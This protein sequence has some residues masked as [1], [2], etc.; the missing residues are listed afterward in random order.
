MVGALSPHGNLGSLESPV[1]RDADMQRRA[2]LMCCKS[3]SKPN[4]GGPLRCLCPN[5]QSATYIP[6]EYSILLQVVEISSQRVDRNTNLEVLVPPKGGLS[7]KYLG[8][9]KCTK[10]GIC[11]ANPDR[12][13]RHS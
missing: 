5:A 12:R 6:T 1:A 9:H 4:S 8:Y 10:Q 2:T 13:H 11:W 7:D 3:R